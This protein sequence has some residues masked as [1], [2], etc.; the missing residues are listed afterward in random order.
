MT[1]NVT[2]KPLGVGIRNVFDGYRIDVGIDPKKEGQPA[3]YAYELITPVEDPKLGGV[4]LRIVH[5]DNVY[6]KARAH[7]DFEDNIRVQSA[8][9][10]STDDVPPQGSS[11]AHFRLRPVDIEVKRTPRHGGLIFMFELVI[12]FVPYVG[13]LYNISQ[14][15]YAMATGKD[16]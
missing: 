16:F 13:V 14:L 8:R 3:A 11:L 15:V 2:P 6:I 12:G 10:S 9:L 4:I 7:E 5:T 1:V